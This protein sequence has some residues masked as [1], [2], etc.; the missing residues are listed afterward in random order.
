MTSVE[1]FVGYYRPLQEMK[2]TNAHELRILT[3]DGQ[4]FNEIFSLKFKLLPILRF[5]ASTNSIPKFDEIYFE[6]FTSQIVFVFFK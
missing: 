1:S 3:A 4:T 5:T 6:I 2:R